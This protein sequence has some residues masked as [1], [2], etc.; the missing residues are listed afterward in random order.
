MR[1]FAETINQNPASSQSGLAG[2]FGQLRQ[3]APKLVRMLQR[4]IELNPLQ[5]VAACDV[6][7]GR[8]DPTDGPF[9]GFFASQYLGVERDRVGMSVPGMGT[10]LEVKVLYGA[11]W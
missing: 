8:V 1:R 9:A 7:A 5:T 11:S 3:F 6:E 4:S 10:G 2:P